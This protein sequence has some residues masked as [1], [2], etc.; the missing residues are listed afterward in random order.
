MFTMQYA[1]LALMLRSSTLI[2]G[3]NSTS[4]TSAAIEINKRFGISDET[5]PNSFWPV[6]AWNIGAA[7]APMVILPIMEDFGVRI[8]YLV[9]NLP[10][11][12]EC[13]PITEVADICKPGDIHLICDIRNTSICCSK[14]C[15]LD[16]YPIYCWLLR[17]SPSRCHG[18]NHSRHLDG[19][20]R[21]KPTSD[22]LCVL[23]SCWCNTWASDWWCCR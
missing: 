17:R 18:W 16:C 11:Q 4:I 22:I 6:T 3:L 8:G 2:V 23:T 15:H 12:G 10:T 13:L 21:T 14:S 1:R 5:F 20:C 19:T 7:L 9:R